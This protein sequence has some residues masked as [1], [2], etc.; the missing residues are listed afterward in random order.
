MLRAPISLAIP[1]IFSDRTDV[2][3]GRDSGTE[4]GGVGAWR[5]ADCPEL[6]LL[7]VIVTPRE[8]S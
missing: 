5:G 1:V 4:T 6:S 3:A 2:G 8:L 7:L